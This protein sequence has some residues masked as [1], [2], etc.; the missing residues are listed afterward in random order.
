[1]TFRQW[2]KT[3]TGRRG[4]IGLLAQDTEIAFN[5]YRYRPVG[6]EPPNSLDG[7]LIFL[8]EHQAAPKIKKALR[9]AWKEYEQV[10]S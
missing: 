5:P 9:R 3:Q 1:M 10:T 2:L 6:K 7:W 4:Y 8:T